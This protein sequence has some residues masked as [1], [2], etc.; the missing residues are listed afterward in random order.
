M[1]NN[2][3]WPVTAAWWWFNLSFLGEV[4]GS[5]VTGLFSARE[6]NKNRD[7]QREMSD[8]SYQRGVADMRA[9][10]L[11]PILAAKLGGASTPGGAMATIP[12]LGATMV[13][14]KQAETAETQMESNV[15]KQSMEIEKLAADIEATEA[16]TQVLKAQLPKIEAEVLKIAADTG[17]RQAMTAIPAMVDDLVGSFRE[18][19]GW[20]TRGDITDAIRDFI[21]IR[22]RK[23]AGDHAAGE[24]PFIEWNRERVLK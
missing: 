22:I 18:L 24:R 23:D 4:L 13:S 16:Q 2:L 14:A 1:L 17:F 11:N 15:E 5:V 7:F 19:S 8:T 21:R 3:I 9:A 10:G 6:A 12:D 20:L